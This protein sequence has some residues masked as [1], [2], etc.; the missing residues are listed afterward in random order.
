[1]KI[2]KK[3]QQEIRLGQL[4][5]HAQSPYNDGWTREAYQKEYE[6]LLKKIEKQKNCEKH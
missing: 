4:K 3:L 5:V 6:K 1:M 2:D